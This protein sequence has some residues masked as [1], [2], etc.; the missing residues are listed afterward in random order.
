M[1]SRQ[2]SIAG[3][4]LRLPV[5]SAPAA[6]AALAGALILGGALLWFNPFLT[7]ERTAFAT[8]PTPPALF[9]VTS[10]ELAP[11]GQA[12]MRAVTI[13]PQSRVAVFELRPAKQT[14]SGGPPVHLV[15]T[16][17][18]YRALLAVPG[19][20]PGGVVSLPIAA[21]KRAEIGTACFVNEGHSTVLLPGTAE[22]RTISRSTM[23]INGRYVVGDVALSFVENGPHSL[24]SRL[25]EIFEHASNVTDRLVPVWLIWILTVI[26]A[27]GVPVAVVAALYLALREGEH[28]AGDGKGALRAQSST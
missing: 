2:V 9:G 12:C 1:R 27:F 26:V 21:P 24:I 11:H 18:G 3:R 16:A 7:G 5:P 20:Y 19:G 23:L 10:F 22:P 4:A 13:T 8:V 15:L 25:G 17:P 6:C 14:P 28:A